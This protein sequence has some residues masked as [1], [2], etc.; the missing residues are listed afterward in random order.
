[1]RDADRSVG[2]SLRQPR[3][4][5]ISLIIK[6]RKGRLMWISMSVCILCARRACPSTQSSGDTKKFGH[7]DP[8][9]INLA[10]CAHSK[11]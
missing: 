5:E 7:A 10:L 2:A 3:I 4:I 6:A 11:N 8:D 1:M 9:R